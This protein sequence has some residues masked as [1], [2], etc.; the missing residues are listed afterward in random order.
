A[1]RAA[2]SDAR[3]GFEQALAILETLPE[4]EAA[5]ED[6][7]EIRLELRSVLSQ[8]GEASAQLGR[9]REAQDIARRLRDE[10]R[11]GRAYA[12]LVNAHTALG[13]YEEALAAAARGL[14]IA[15]RSEDLKLGIL[16]TSYLVLSH[17]ELGN[18]QRAVE[19]GTNNIR[20]LPSEWTREH[21]G[22]AA[23]ISVHSR[24][25]VCNCLAQLGRFEKGIDHAQEAIRIAEPP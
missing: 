6:C 14:E 23:F 17:H 20:A 8:L 7:F 21:L 19:L 18:Y 12:Y 25:C 11:L 1:A 10:P 22:N 16:T 2:L 9:L 4:T 5:R 3:T 15:D 24:W 13:Q